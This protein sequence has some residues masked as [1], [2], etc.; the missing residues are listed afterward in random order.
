MI[1]CR[2]ESERQYSIS[3]VEAMR[4]ASGK[5]NELMIAN[6]KGMNNNRFIFENVESKSSWNR[7]KP[8]NSVKCEHFIF[9]LGH[10]AW[11][12]RSS[13]EPENKVQ[14]PLV[15]LDVHQPPLPHPRRETC[16][17]FSSKMILFCLLIIVN[18]IF[19]SAVLVPGMWKTRKTPKQR[20][21]NTGNFK[22]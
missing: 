19:I 18:Q 16:P 17:Y 13:I 20:F 8:K 15:H 3:K 2:S 1:F 22:I 14:L 9:G 10:V 6:H 11:M 5:K 21:H 7:N 12:V 4:N